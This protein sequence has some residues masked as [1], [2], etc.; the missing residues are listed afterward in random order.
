MRT[1]VLMLAFLWCVSAQDECNSRE[2]QG[3][4]VCVC[5]AS[6]CDQPGIIDFP[7]EGS[8]TVVTS[9]QE[10]LRF[11]VETFAVSG[12]EIPGAVVV[13]VNP[14]DVYQT[15]LGFGGAFTDAAG[16]GVVTLAPEAQE[17]FLRSY[18]SAEGNAYSIGRI[19]IAG[20]DCSARTYS[21]D[22]VEGDIDLEHWS[23]QEED[24]NYKIPLLLRA[25]ELSPQPLKLFGSPWAPPAW[26]KTNGMFNGS[27][28]LIKE[29]WQPYANYLVKFVDAYEGE[30][31]GLWGLT[32]QNE[33]LGGLDNWPINCCGW[34]AEEM[35]DWMKGNLGP[36][37]EAAGY[38]RLQMMMVDFNRDSLP[39]FVETCLEDPECAQYVDGTAVHWYSDYIVGPEV[40]DQTHDLSPSRFILYSEACYN[41]DETLLGSWFRAEDY[42]RHIFEAVNHYS[43]G[44]VDWNLALDRHG[45]PNWANNFLDAPIIVDTEA[46]EF[47]KQP[48]FYALGH[49]SKFVLPGAERISSTVSSDSFEVAAFI[50]PSGRSV[51]LLL[52]KGEDAVDVSVTDGTRF[53]NYNMPAKSIQTILN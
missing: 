3:G 36:S 38:R 13:T 18:F 4:I 26:M 11:N 7:E 29:M 53:L 34:T 50:D 25:I 10:G 31:V 30:G 33:P 45:G 46:G 41:F 52:N 12:E 21:Y 47:F 6:Y 43:A 44:W 14:D 37:L 24:Y 17:N 1:A 27:G 39:W 22:D 20:A 23:L 5:D 48:M 19:P 40:L 28:I 49:F 42:S 51:V 32:P 15:M 2:M 16:Q 35:R 8:F 9:N